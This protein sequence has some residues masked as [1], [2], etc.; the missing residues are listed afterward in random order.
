MLAL[1]LYGISLSSSLVI[2]VFVWKPMIFVNISIV[3][4]H[5]AEMELRFQNQ[6]EKINSTAEQIF[7]IF[8]RP[9]PLLEFWQQ[10]N[11]RRRIFAIKLSDVDT[12]IIRI[13]SVN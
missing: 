4:Y 12:D 8:L 5:N 6:S 9:D 7:Q 2:S 10:K 1:E 3:L 11:T 13:L